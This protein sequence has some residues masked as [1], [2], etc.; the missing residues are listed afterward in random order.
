[1]CLGYWEKQKNG[2]LICDI[3]TSKD[4]LKLKLYIRVYTADPYHFIG[5][6]DTV[7]PEKG[8]K[9]KKRKITEFKYDLYYPL[10]HPNEFENDL[11]RKFAQLISQG[12]TIAVD[13]ENPCDMCPFPRIP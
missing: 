7:W 3:T 9:W 5:C 8:Y 6:D 4:Y 1:M 13:P 12:Y 2:D 11:N 10:I